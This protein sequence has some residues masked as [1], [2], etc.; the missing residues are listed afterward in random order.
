ML[1]IVMGY[2]KIWGLLAANWAL[3]TLRMLPPENDTIILADIINHD[4]NPILLELLE[5]LVPV[6]GNIVLSTFQQSPEAM[7]K[8]IN[9]ISGNGVLGCKVAKP[10]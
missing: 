6:L 3:D 1:W 4:R 2:R 10:H 8:L 5:K 9:S 7:Q